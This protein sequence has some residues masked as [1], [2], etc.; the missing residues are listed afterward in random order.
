MSIG[1]RSRG[2]RFHHDH[3]HAELCGHLRTSWRV[4]AMQLEGSVHR[5]ELRLIVVHEMF[6]HDVANRLPGAFVLS[7]ALVTFWTFSSRTKTV[8]FFLQVPT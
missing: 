1:G 4:L 7:Y 2:P 5:D 6:L 8:F 3:L